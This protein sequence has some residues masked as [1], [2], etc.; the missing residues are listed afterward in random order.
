MKISR[1]ALPYMVATSLSP[2]AT[3]HEKCGYSKLRW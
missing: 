3:E 1:A 2:K